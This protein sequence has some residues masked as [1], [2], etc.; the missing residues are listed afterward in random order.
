M[1]SILALVLVCSCCSALAQGREPSEDELRAA[2]TAYYDAATETQRR[3]LAQCQ[4]GQLKGAPCFSVL[5]TGVIEMQVQSFRKMAPC[6]V[7][8]D[9]RGYICTYAPVIRVSGPTSAANEG[10][11]RM[12]SSRTTWLFHRTKSGVQ[13][14]PWPENE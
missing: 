11:G 12:L 10:A 9:R 8:K 1:R 3:T 5:M 13:P 6:Q 4:S 2:V 7:S 14:Q